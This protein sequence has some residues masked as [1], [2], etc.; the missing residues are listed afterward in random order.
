MYERL[1]QPL[2][3]YLLGGFMN[4]KEF[5]NAVQH[6]TDLHFCGF[7]MKEFDW[8]YDILN[9]KLPS[10]ETLA[11]VFNEDKFCDS[12]LKF[13]IR[14]IYTTYLGFPLLNKELIET[15][16]DVIGNKRVLEVAS[17][18]GFVSK[19]LSDAGVNI[20]ATD[21]CYWD[22]KKSIG[23]NPRP[24][25]FLKDHPIELIDG[26][27][28]IEKYKDETDMVLMT[29]PPLGSSFAANVLND[30]IKYK[31]PL[32]YCGEDWGGCTADDDFFELADKECIIRNICTET[33]VPFN[34]I[35]DEWWLIVPAE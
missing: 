16:S 24:L 30:C 15:L 21:I 10:K 17:G 26:I 33:N 34:Y 8:V 25:E 18:S 9:G 12:D 5:R 32:I 31:L 11:S 35:Y 3:F 28:A 29:W 22:W 1:I 27:S 19:Y 6:Y 20:R 13:A 14:D 23:K 2:I 7:N 4:R